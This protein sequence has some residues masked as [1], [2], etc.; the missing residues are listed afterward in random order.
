MKTLFILIFAH[1]LADTVLQPRI[2]AE[3]KRRRCQAGL[4]PWYY[5]MTAHAI[6]HGGCVCLVTGSL[7]Y[8]LIEVALHWVIDYSKGRWIACLQDQA[9]HGLCKLIYSITI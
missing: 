2:M 8:G 9:A 3:G 1:T 4:H 5:W 7:A 6:I